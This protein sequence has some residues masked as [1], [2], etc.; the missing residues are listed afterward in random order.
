VQRL[1]RPVLADPVHDR[2]LQCVVERCAAPAAA[3]SVPL[4][5]SL[6]H[7]PPA[8]PHTLN[9]LAAPSKGINIGFFAGPPNACP[10][11]AGA[12]PDHL[13]DIT[14]GVCLQAS[15][16]QWLKFGCNAVNVT[17]SYW[18]A[19]GCA[20][21]PYAVS[22]ALPLG[23]SATP[24]DPAKPNPS[25][26]PRVAVCGKKQ[27]QQEE[28]AALGAPVPLPM[29]DARAAVAA[30]LAEAAAAAVARARAL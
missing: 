23:C 13:Q 10:V 7:T 16:S 2:A 9:T 18:S 27:Q 19:K 5:S 30:A 22:P 15:S 17:L 28:G 6:S 11:P 20:G 21:A 3:P 12:E 29:A 26:G 25:A 14:T 1:W 4:L 8:P 24:A